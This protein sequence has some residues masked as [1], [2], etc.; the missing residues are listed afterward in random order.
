MTDPNSHCSPITWDQRIPN[1][2]LFDR[3]FLLSRPPTILQ[4]FPRTTNQCTDSSKRP[5][6][7]FTDKSEKQAAEFWQNNVVSKE[8]KGVDTIGHSKPVP[9]KSLLK[10]HP[11]RPWLHSTDKNIDRESQLLN[12]NYYNPQDCIT[13]SVYNDLAGFRRI[14]DEALLREMQVNSAHMVN[15]RLWDTV[16]SVKMLE[17]IDYNLTED[18]KKCSRRRYGSKSKKSIK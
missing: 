11:E 13:P 12:L 3:Q 5:W 18:I 6:L 2:P 8:I 16:T 17:P 7:V 9:I 4:D 15:G 1:E 14:S 10:K